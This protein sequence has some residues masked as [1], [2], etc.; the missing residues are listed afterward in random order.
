MGSSVFCCPGTAAAGSCSRSGVWLP[1]DCWKH[2]HGR[3][4]Y[5]QMKS[6]SPELYTWRRTRKTRCL[7][8]ACSHVC[9]MKQCQRERRNRGD[10]RSGSVGRGGRG[11]G[12]AGSPKLFRLAH[13]LPVHL[14]SLIVPTKDSAILTVGM[15][16]RVKT[17][18]KGW[19]K[20]KNHSC[21]GKKKHS[22]ETRAIPIATQQGDYVKLEQHEKGNE[23]RSTSGES[24]AVCQARD[25]ECCHG[26]RG[27]LNQRR[28]H[29]RHIR[30]RRCQHGQ[31]HDEQ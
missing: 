17:S 2:R 29:R 14:D 10:N 23:E 20:K 15:L 11:E 16:R 25:R 12:V 6:P 8:L 27:L 28:Q 7:P 21:R 31:K 1:A 30:S 4:L 3:C 5:R 19:N 9:L 24:R 18:L 13:L 22:T 26:K